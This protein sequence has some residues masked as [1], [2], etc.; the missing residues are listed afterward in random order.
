MTSIRWG[1]FWNKSKKSEEYLFY[2]FYEETS[3]IEPE[4][5][6]WS[7]GIAYDTLSNPGEMK[8]VDVEKEEKIMLRRGS[9]LFRGGIHLYFQRPTKK[10]EEKWEKKTE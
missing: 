8:L 1:L 10:E 3:F 6:I 2:E 4:N 9:R 7:M 5:C